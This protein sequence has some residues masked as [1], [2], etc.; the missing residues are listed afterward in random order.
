M[1][2][3]RHLKEEL[4]NY[5]REVQTRYRNLLAQKGINASSKLSS[6][7]T[8]V[9]EEKGSDLI[10]SLRLQDYWRWVEYGTRAGAGHGKG[11]FPPVAPFID[12][13]QA[14]G[15]SPKPMRIEIKR[16]TL[17]PRVVMVTPKPAQAAYLIARKVWNTGTIPKN[18]LGQATWDTDAETEKLERALAED[19]RIWLDDVLKELG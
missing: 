19:I 13:M 12:W 17:P 4:W 16:K 18:V 10:L 5:G 8:P 3:Y 6:T 14:K 9:L 1:I 15:L 11:K 2:D 7:A